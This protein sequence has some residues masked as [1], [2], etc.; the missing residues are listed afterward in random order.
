MCWANDK[1]NI[2]ETENS[3]AGWVVGSLAMKSL[4]IEGDTRRGWGDGDTYDGGGGGGWGGSRGGAGG[5]ISGI[6]F[7]N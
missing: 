6:C 1:E 2:R 7:K 3:V 5:G 4:V